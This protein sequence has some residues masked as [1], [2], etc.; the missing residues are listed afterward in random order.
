MLKISELKR[1]ILTYIAGSQPSA[2]SANG[3]RGRQ[4]ATSAGYACK[5]LRE[6]WFEV[7]VAKIQA[8]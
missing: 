4:R 1:G 2:H 5:D 8:T 6:D 3:L 7:S